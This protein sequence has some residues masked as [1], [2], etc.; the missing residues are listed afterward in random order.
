MFRY[1]E[2]SDS[3]KLLAAA[4][5]KFAKLLKPVS[6]AG[7]RKR[8]ATQKWSIAEIM[9]HIADTEVVGG[10]RIRAILG[11]PGSQIIGFDQDVLVT[12]LHYNKRQLRKSFEQY[13][14]LREPIPRC[15]R[16]SRPNSGSTMA[17][18]ERNHRNNCADVRRTRSHSPSRNGAHSGRNE[19]LSV[20]SS[21]ASERL[22]P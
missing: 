11:A 20:A 15:S 10:Y 16:P 17:C 6:P 8:P 7:A 19:E 4:P 2:G 9:A 5:A 12:A 14:G 18:N 13:R 1:I 22:A 21:H 3:V